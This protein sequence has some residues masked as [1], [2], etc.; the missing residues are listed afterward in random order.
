[1]VAVNARGVAGIAGLAH[2]ERA[3]VTAARLG[4]A[5]CSPRNPSAGVAEENSTLPAGP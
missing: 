5:A 1:L 4:K 3:S 2:G